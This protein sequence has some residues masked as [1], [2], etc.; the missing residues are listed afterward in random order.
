MKLQVPFVQLPLSFDAARLR[1]EIDALGESVWRPHP[2][3]FAGNSALPLISVN[4]DPQSD[5]ISGPMR[6]TPHLD[7]CPYLRQ[8]LASLGAVWGRSRLMRLSG[9]AEV[10]RHADLAYYWRDRVRVHVPIQTQPTVRFQCADAEVNMAEGECWIFDTWAPHRVINANP[11]Q[12]IHLVADTVGSE[13]FWQHASGGQVAGRPVS[14]WRPQRVPYVASNAPELIF[15]SENLGNVMTPWEL[16]EH[17]NFILT[18]AMPVPQLGAIHQLCSRFNATW[19][20]LW[21]RF[22]AS[23]A[24]WPAYRAALDPFNVEMQRLGEGMLMRNGMRFLGA[25]RAMIVQAALT[26]QGA[27][28]LVVKGDYD[29][30]AFATPTAVAA[31][32]AA[33][34]RT[35][36]THAVD[37]MPRFDRP[38]IIISPPRSGS[39][40]LFETL[41][42]ARNVFT[43]GDESHVQI[44]GMPEL[45]P[46]NHNFD[47]NALGAELALES[48]V[49]RLRGRFF[50]AL[51]DRDGR[52]PAAGAVRLLEKTP[53]NALRIPFLRK[54]FPDAHFIY[55]HRDPREVLSSMMEAWTSGRFRTYPKL[56]GWSGPDWSLLLV[57][58]WRELIGKPLPQIVARQWQTTMRI[59][60]DDLAM[61][62]RDHVHAIHYDALLDDPDREMRRLCAELGFEWDLSLENNLPRSRHT[63]S[64]PEKEKWRRHEREIASVWDSVAETCERADAMF[65]Q[66]SKR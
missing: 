27:G 54:V 39:T 46:A 41:A 19:L 1:S 33:P 66:A 5:S 21:A 37:A 42:R 20:G 64:A 7:A 59:L 43:V 65:A 29:P 52:P 56:P 22:G 36:A 6:P 44:E 2:Q 31:T 62:P 17:L 16:R 28:G 57:P 63:V 4:G 38:V 58:G 45:H 14:G 55:L 30:D 47:S 53:K 12:R 11:D 50:E 24:G 40:L 8:V 26:D 61:G 48:V 18:E 10:P 60:L 35:P 34:G 25:F 23:E 3:G 49:A 32:Q 9:H 15:E 13:V 51:R